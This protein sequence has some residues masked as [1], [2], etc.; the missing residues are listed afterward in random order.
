[1]YGD[2]YA[3]FISELSRRLKLSTKMQ[4]MIALSLA[5]SCPEAS[6]SDCKLINMVLV[7]IKTRT[8]TRA[9]LTNFLM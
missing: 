7:V 6:K 8:F 2:R 5:E 4:L 9:L 3:D 1:M